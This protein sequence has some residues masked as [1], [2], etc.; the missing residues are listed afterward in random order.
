MNNSAGQKNEVLA[1][2]IKFILSALNRLNSGRTVDDLEFAVIYFWTGIE[3]VLKQPLI[4]EHWS[5]VFQD[6]NAANL[7]RFNAGDFT[8]VDFRN[9]KSRLNGICG[10]KLKLDPFDNVRNR[11]NRILHM[12]D[13]RESDRDGI[14]SEI[15]SALHVVILFL[16]GQGFLSELEKL[17]ELSSRFDAYINNRMREIRESL[18]SAQKNGKFIMRC[19]DCHQVALLIG[20]DYKCLFCYSANMNSLVVA[21][22][23]QRP[24]DPYNSGAWME[25][26]CKKTLMRFA[27][28]SYTPA[29]PDHYVCCGC[30]VH[31]SMFSSVPCVQVNEVEDYGDDI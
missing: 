30:G 17:Q 7:N 6:I 15:S 21:Y 5:L 4:N 13:I 25:N 31:A 23:N 26:G 28:Y 11:R 14:L 22:E 24:P 29:A 18:D 10:L 20:A 12:G 3:I 1:R 8:S 27:C 16:R 2:G 9:L 19:P